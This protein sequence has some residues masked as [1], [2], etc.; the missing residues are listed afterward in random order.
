MQYLLHW[1]YC[2]NLDGVSLEVW[3]KFFWLWSLMLELA[4]PSSDTF[5]LLLSE[6]VCS[7]RPA[8]ALYPA[9]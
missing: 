5:P 9:L 4:F 6:L 2:R 7:N 1:V 8:A 3:S